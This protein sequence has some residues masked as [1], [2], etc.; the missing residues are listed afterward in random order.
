MHGSNAFTHRENIGFGGDFSNPLMPP[1]ILVDLG[2][3]AGRQARCRALGRQVAARAGRAGLD[4][5]RSIFPSVSNRHAARRFWTA[6]DGR[7]R[8]A[9]MIRELED[10]LR[11]Q[12]Q[13]L[14]GSS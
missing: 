10:E 4:K 1:A 9:Q 3:I 14:E 11:Q 12:L 13:E 2:F 7:D 5:S 6:P 8:M